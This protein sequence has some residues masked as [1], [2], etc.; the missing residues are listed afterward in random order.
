MT[1]TRAQRTYPLTLTADALNTGVVSA[2]DFAAEDGSTATSNGKDHSG[3]N[4]HMTAPGTAPTIVTTAVGKGR[5]TTLGR[6]VTTNY[7]QYA[8]ASTIG[9]NVGTGDFTVYR[10][11]R[12]PSNA[13]ATTSVRALGRITDGGGTKI[14]FALYEVVATGGWHLTIDMG[15]NVLNWNS[16]GNPANAPNADVHW[17][18]A[19][20]GG[21]VKNYVNG[22]QITSVSN[23]ADILGT[24]GAS[25][26]EGVY[27]AGSQGCDAVF[28]DAI[29]W[30][31]GLSGAEITAHT[32]NP[33]NYYVNSAVSDSIAVSAPAAS[34][35][36]SAASFNISGTLAGG[37]TV[38][39]VE[40]SFNGGAY[41]TIATN[42]AGGVFSGALTG[43]AAGT[44]T[45]TVRSKNGSTVVATATVTGV[46]AA[47]DSIAFTV[48]NT[49][50]TAAVPYRVFQ[51]DTLDRASVRITGTY[52]GSPTSIQYQFNGG[53]WTTLVAT[54]ASGVF[55]A[56][57][58]LQGPAQ[59]ALNIRFANNTGITASIPG[60]SVGDVFM[61]MGQ[62][63]HVGKCPSYVAPVA[64]AGHPGWIP[65]VYGKN[66]VWRQHLETAAN[67]FDDPTGAIYSV[68]VDTGAASYFGALATK[69]MAGNVPVAF[70]PCAVGS[71]SI[72][73]WGVNTATTSL[74]GAALARATTIGDHKAVLWWQ[75]EYETS[76][77]VTQASYAASLGSL[78]D[79]WF[80]RTGRKWFVWAINSTATGSNFQAIH[81][82]IIQVGQTNSH[83]AGY[84]DLNG[85]FNAGIHYG[86]VGEIA[87][88][89]NRT[90]AA[91]NNAYNYA[92]ASH[93]PATILVNGRPV[94]VAVAQIGTGQKPIVYLNGRFKLRA[95]AEGTPVV[96]VNGR[97]RLLAAGE[98]LD[99]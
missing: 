92:G 4:R 63:N 98:T 67:V 82:A 57:V 95:E 37:T 56:T 14:A 52:V 81:D 22:V 13:P 8:S 41:A 49:P 72:A 31:R 53:A 62:S 73:G 69:I 28:L 1:V 76:G 43:Q 27:I 99:I 77:S 9:L 21:V 66:G 23:A 3:N 85:S 18:M 34:A 80:A 33:Y 93:F 83:C 60:V 86:T 48:P 58:V 11:F 91:L 65:S 74:Y 40:A 75:G 30:N 46:V 64:P 42:P 10:R 61:V 45:L 78:V 35:T 5:E 6:T 55:D 97:Y 7:Y 16:A 50:A 36:V 12:M 87:E 59:N 25:S 79:D 20:I 29:H 89:A 84:A 47:S 17:H 68:E 51:R 32:A 44:G 90:F 70:V 24:A 39:A 88:I 15:T 96:F 54:P 38:T 26:T 2:F 19:R 71:T 94:K